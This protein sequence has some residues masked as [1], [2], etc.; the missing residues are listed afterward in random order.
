[1]TVNMDRVIPLK[2]ALLEVRVLL[3]ILKQIQVFLYIISDKM[4]AKKD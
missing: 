3:N 2:Q 1:M 4:E